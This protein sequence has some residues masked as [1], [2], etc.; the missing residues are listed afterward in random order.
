MEKSKAIEIIRD[1]F[2][3]NPDLLQELLDD[4]E[5]VGNRKYVFFEFYSS[6]SIIV[7]E[8]IYKRVKLGELIQINSPGFKYHGTEVVVEKKRNHSIECYIPNNERV[9]I[10]ITPSSVRFIPQP[11]KKKLE[12]SEGDLVIIK[13]A[14]FRPRYE[15]GDLFR[16]VW[17]GN[18]Y[19]RVV[20]KNPRF[21][22]YQ[23]SGSSKRIG[24]TARE[25]I[26][27]K[28]YYTISVYQMDIPL[29][30]L[31]DPNERYGEKMG[32]LVKGLDSIGF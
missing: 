7:N 26:D 18:K 10:R 17:K 8:I 12:V 31:Q 19:V 27:K 15:E 28:S 24:D 5:N 4:I 23:L 22:V 2:S 1:K 14:K 16:V 6:E 30:E 21:E 3:Y 13:D 9:R 29:T 25:M 20:P 11:D 32:S